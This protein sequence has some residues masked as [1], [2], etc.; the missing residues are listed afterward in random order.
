MQNQ[1]KKSLPLFKAVTSKPMIFINILIG[2]FGV[3]FLLF[4]LA[5]I[6]FIMTNSSDE[7]GLDEIATVAF[8]LIFLFALVSFLGLLFYYR[9]RMYT[10]TIIDEKGIRYLNRFN[11]AIV[12]DLPWSSFAKKED[13]I[14][15]LEPPKYDVNSNTPMK[16]LFDQFYWPVLVNGKVIVNSD[17]FLGKHFFA[18]I[19]SN[20]LELIRTFVLG[21]AHYRPDITIDPAIFANHYINS[22]TYS[23]NYRQRRQ[24]QIFGGLFCVVILVIL[25]FVVY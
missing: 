8:F 9:K 17:A 13:V 3:F 19:Y 6:I 11:D 10:T 14:Y 5:G 22:E 24:I 4:F 1:I 2:L 12:K 18:M 23:I 7:T 25:Y 20:R 21:I 15:V 16:S